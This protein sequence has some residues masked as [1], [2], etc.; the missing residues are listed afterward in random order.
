MADP[1]N[2]GQF[3]NRSDTRAQ[4][5]KGGRASSG[6][7][8]GP[9]A[10]DPHVTGRMGAAAQSHEAKVRGGRNSHRGR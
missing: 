9:N 8:G 7:F 3:G 6:S 5:A 1:K 2:Q 4:A 10:A